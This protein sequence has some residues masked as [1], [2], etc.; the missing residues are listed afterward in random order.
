MDSRTWL[1][2]ALAWAALGCGRSSLYF[3]PPDVE[4]CVEVGSSSVGCSFLAS[5]GLHLVEPVF[6]RDEVDPSRREPDGVFVVNP[7][8][9]E[10]VTV[11]A[12]EIVEGQLEPR[13]LG[14]PLPLLPAERA[15]VR[16]PVVSLRQASGLSAGG[17]VQLV[18]DGPFAASQHG[19]YRPFLG[20][21]SALLLPD[22]ALGQRYVVVAYPPHLEHFQG[23]GTPSFFEIAAVEDDTE[24]RW[25]PRQG[26]TA[27][28]TGVP[29]VEAGQWSPTLVLRRHEVLRILAAGRGGGPSEHDVS[30][31]LIETS[32]PVRVVAGSRCSAV[33]VSFDPGEGC[34]PLL[35]QLVP[36]QQWG[37]TTVVPHPPL[38]TTESHHVRIYAGAPGV[39]V[40]AE[41]SVLPAEPH[42]FEHEGQLLDVVV[43]HG[44][45]F[46]LEADGPIMAAAY[47]QTRDR[48]VELGDPAMVQL[49]SV[50]AYLD[51]YAIA[52]GTEWD[53]HFAQL[54]RRQGGAQVV[55]DGTIVEGWEPV[56][57]WET[58]VVSIDEG[59]HVVRS[60][61]PFGLTQYGWTN[62]LHEACAPFA[63]HGTCQTSYAHPGGMST[64]LQ[65]E[66]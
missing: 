62:S 53:Q 1:I 39:C 25:R 54:V 28:A 43:P 33:P 41:P 2:G 46:V 12:F 4:A 64:A 50:E 21:D 14:D 36:V 56:A 61:E 31:T 24:V 29:E 47:L 42:C 23:L 58:A 49:V 13:P 51:R 9:R 60:D 11:Q 3:P 7:D 63:A 48:D 66:R 8:E 6:D 40:T 27:A 18:A 38:R 37:H 45:S 17:L 10:V 59:S 44:T 19:P 22:S 34:D 5:P 26:S 55:L 65:R 57:G 30:G 16:L 52:T 20:N 35:E 32:A 15:M